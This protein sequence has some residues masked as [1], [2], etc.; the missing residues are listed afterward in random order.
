LSSNDGQIGF[1]IID[2]DLASNWDDGAEWKVDSMKFPEELA[3]IFDMNGTMVDDQ[4]FQRRAWQFVCARH[5]RSLSD[6][7]YRLHVAGHKE[8]DVLSYL[9]G[10]DY[11]EDEGLKIGEEKRKIYRETFDP[12]TAEVPGFRSLLSELE[13]AGV[14]LA[15]ATSASKATLDFILDRLNIR[16]KFRVI[17]QGNEVANGKPAPDIYLLTA[18]KIG[19]SPSECVVFEDSPAGVASAK[20]AGMV[21]IGLTTTL[22]REELLAEKAD[23]AIPDFGEIGPSDIVSIVKR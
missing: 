21:C 6:E 14:P 12:V 18:S 5:D 4:P 23:L 22:S 7:E 3:V 20:A 11:P 17:V 1:G 2:G 15:L 13:S 9:F 19:V 8:K 16:S 10:A